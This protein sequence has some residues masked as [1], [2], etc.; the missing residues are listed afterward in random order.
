MVAKAKDK[1]QAVKGQKPRDDKKRQ[2]GSTVDKQRVSQIVKESLDNIGQKLEGF[3]L[4]STSYKKIIKL[5]KKRDKHQILETA[6]ESYFNKEELMPYQA[7]LIKL[8]QHLE[9]TGR[10]MIILFDG[11]DASGKGGTIRRV[12]RYM[13]EKHYRVVALGK[14][15]DNQQTELHMKRYIEQFPAPAKSCCLIAAGTIGPWWSRS[16]DFAP[17]SNTSVL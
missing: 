17:K 8:Q 11:R 14:P 3:D 15:S 7:E 16:W 2:A 4:E 1:K 6:M 9:K 10:K 5:L 12:S 13:N